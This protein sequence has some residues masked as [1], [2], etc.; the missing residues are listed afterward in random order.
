LLVAAPGLQGAE[1]EPDEVKKLHKAG[2]MDLPAHT[3]AQTKIAF[4]SSQACYSSGLE[5]PSADAQSQA[6]LKP[7]AGS[8][9]PARCADEHC[10]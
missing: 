2:A 7:T 8:K 1:H 4:N 3:Q 5:S 10:R 6:A 9:G